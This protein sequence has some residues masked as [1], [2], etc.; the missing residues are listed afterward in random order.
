[1]FVQV[2]IIFNGCFSMDGL[3]SI[4]GMFEHPHGTNIPFQY[5]GEDAVYLKVLKDVVGHDRYGFRHHSPP[6]VILADPVTDFGIVAIDIIFYRKPDVPNGLSIDF[7]GHIAGLLVRFV[8]A[9][10]GMGIAGGVRVRKKIAYIV[11]D[12]SIAGVVN[13]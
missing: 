3:V 8:G 7:D 13:Q 5:T 9:Y 11:P 12:V 6:P 10:P 1:M 4:P 2:L